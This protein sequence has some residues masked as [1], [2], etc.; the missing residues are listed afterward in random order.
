MTAGQLVIF[1]AA[2]VI[3]AAAGAFISWKMT[4]RSLKNQADHEL[5]NLK[6]TMTLL[7]EKQARDRKKA[8]E[9]IMKLLNERI[10]QPLT[11]DELDDIRRRNDEDLT[12]QR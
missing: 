9:A 2:I 8:S 12:S 6:A 11:E 4:A 3:S 10:D 7:Q 1:A 5:T